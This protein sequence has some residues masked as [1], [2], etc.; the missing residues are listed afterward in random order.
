M[1]MKEE[2]IVQL[3]DH[4][5]ES[6]KHEWKKLKDLAEEW[7]A[8]LRD[9]EQATLRVDGAIGEAEAK[10]CHLETASTE[11]GLPPSLDTAGA[12]RDEVE[13]TLSGLNQVEELVLSAKMQSDTKPHLQVGH[14]L[15]ALEKRLTALKESA[16]HR[17]EQLSSLVVQVKILQKVLI[18]K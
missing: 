5:T 1:K 17:R 8:Q 14:K 16:A 11:W 12:E 7:D 9:A 15:A 6:L 2:R 13:I 18:L 4:Y 10:L 3:P